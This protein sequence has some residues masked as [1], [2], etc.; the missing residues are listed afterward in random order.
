MIKNFHVFPLFHSLNRSHV[1]LIDKILQ[2]PCDGA[3]STIDFFIVTIYKLYQLLSNSSDDSES[4]EGPKSNH[5][6][7]LRGGSSSP[8]VV[9]SPSEL[10]KRKCI[11]VIV[12]LL[13][14]DKENVINL[15]SKYM[16][17]KSWFYYQIQLK[18]IDTT[19]DIDKF[20]KD[21][22][23]NDEAKSQLGS[24]T[25]SKSKKDIDIDSIEVEEESDEDFYATIIEFTA[26][27]FL[28]FIKVNRESI[29]SVDYLLVL[30]C[31]INYEA[32]EKNEKL[33][34][35]L[36]NI[37][38]IQKNSITE[39]I[40]RFSSF[41]KTGFLPQMSLTASPDG[42]E[43]NLLSGNMN[44]IHRT[45]MMIPK[46]NIDEID[47]SSNDVGI[48]EKLTSV[49]IQNLLTALDYISDLEPAHLQL[50]CDEALRWAI[51]CGDIDHG[52]AIKAAKLYLMYT[53][54]VDEDTIQI[55]IRSIYIMS[56]ILAE[57]IDPNYN[58]GNAAIFTAMQNSPPDYSKAI[59]Y[60]TLLLNILYKCHELM[61]TPNE[62]TFYLALSL[63]QF[64]E[65]IAMPIVTVS[66]KIV[67]DYLENEKDFIKE[68]IAKDGGLPNVLRPLTVM[69]H[70]ESSIELA[71][72]LISTFAI[73]YPKSLIDDDDGQF[74]SF[75]SISS[76]S[77][78]TG[79]IPGPNIKNIASKSKKDKIDS[80]SGLSLLV[81][82]LIPYLFTNQHEE[83]VKSIM[84]SLSTVANEMGFIWFNGRIL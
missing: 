37:C 44:L 35:L 83:S 36:S 32:M 6:K 4:E 38:G 67:I 78:R 72:K 54:T 42:S 30:Y 41:M 27:I 16:S 51:G 64:K 10:N 34:N 39:T 52:T 33:L 61:K 24:S 29:K 63:L 69:N 26:E 8:D 20:M 57:R 23:A 77:S 17:F 53:T 70:N 84:N 60:I 43:P 59:Q 50:F 45:S 18:K 80:K 14:Q 62:D 13:G 47:L 1:L 7:F 56:S 55:I 12:Y 5:V 58:K 79:S 25:R 40:R 9:S 31:L 65:I 75:S 48:I 3:I 21:I 49:P 81:L 19:F 76:L 73:N 2:Q 15:I 82:S 66:L 74:Y 71:F 46:K 28:E 11:A 68:I 22:A